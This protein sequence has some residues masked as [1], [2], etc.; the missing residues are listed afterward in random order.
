[1]FEIGGKGI[2]ME[3]TSN[4][5]VTFPRP[6]NGEKVH[7]IKA[8]VHNLLDEIGDDVERGEVLADLIDDLE[9]DLAL[10]VE[11]LTELLGDAHVVAALIGR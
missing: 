11:Q 4:I 2:Q 9:E 10:R 1:L 8:T 7:A 5:T 3:S 6:D